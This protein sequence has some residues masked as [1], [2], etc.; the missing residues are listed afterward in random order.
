[1]VLHQLWQDVDGVGADDELLVAAIQVAE[2][3]LDL[4]SPHEAILELALLGAADVPDD[5]APE[6]F[7]K[8]TERLRDFFKFEFF[9][10]EKK[11]F[12]R[13]LQQELMRVDPA[14][15]DRLEQGSADHTAMRA[16]RT[17]MTIPPVMED[18]AAMLAF[19]DGATF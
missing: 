19:V 11:I 8:E 9:Y 13:Q 12:R 1:M 16:I 18:I 14:W 2:L 10:P 17:K 4:G 7:W 5:Q 3:S 15:K 6:S